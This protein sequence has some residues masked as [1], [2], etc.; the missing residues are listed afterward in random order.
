[1]LKH[2]YIIA[3]TALALTLAACDSKGIDPVAPGDGMVTMVISVKTIDS[4]PDAPLSRANETYFENPSSK[5]EMLNTLRYII[6]R[7]DG[8]VE[9]NYIF[10]EALQAS[11]NATDHVDYISFKVVGG[12]KKQVYL[13]AN[14]ASVPYDFSTIVDGSVFPTDEIENIQLTASQPGQPLY[15]N[16][17]LATAKFLPLSEHFEVDV[18]E[19]SPTSDGP[20]YDYQTLFITRSTVKF[21]FTAQVV[22]A[23]NSAITLKQI[24]FNEIGDRQY[25][26]PKN[27]EYSPAKYPVNTD[28]RMIV[29]Y[30]VPAAATTAPATFDVNWQ[31][32]AGDSEG[33]AASP[34]LYFPET[35]FNGNYTATIVVNVDG[36]DYQ[37]TASLPNL[38]SLPRNTHVKIDMTLS[39]ESV[40]CQVD[41][42][43]YIG[44]RLN[45]VFGWEELH[46]NQ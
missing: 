23:S 44:V 28:D 26:L 18:K 46:P 22:P 29:A 42:A 31:W 24:I 35:A 1:M 19:A 11:G 10:G 3:L 14:E 38:P 25:L 15:D 13:I 33:K 43:P 5:F 36:N 16:S 41:L 7:P 2:L 32:N 6:V 12:E 34:A 17:D 8:K 40:K 45:P 21:S 20:T 4:Q 9:H 37:Y 27:T 30:D 39:D